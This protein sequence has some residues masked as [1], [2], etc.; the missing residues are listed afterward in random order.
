MYQRILVPVDGSHAANRGLEEAI[1]LAAG[2]PVTLYLLHVV[3]EFVASQGMDGAM[4]IGIPYSDEVLKALREGG[5]RVL[6]KAEAKA[7][8]AGVKAETILVETVGYRVADVI[9]KQAK[10]TRADLIIMGTHGRRG[11]ARLVMGSDAEGVLRG[12]G[13]PVLLLR[14]PDEPRGRARRKGN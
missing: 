13:V 10:K 4:Y 1:K 5:K 14:S 8:K 2:Q 7:S 11:V 3:D 9:L 12:T 6:A